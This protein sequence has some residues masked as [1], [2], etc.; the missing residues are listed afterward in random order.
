MTT[1]A[2]MLVIDAAGVNEMKFVTD[3]GVD[4]LIA[5]ELRNWV[6]VTFGTN[7][8]MLDLLDPQTSIKSLAGI[9]VD[10]ALTS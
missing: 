2:N 8:L 3:Y 7:I 1:V 10:K 5:A 6:N 9:V 4:S